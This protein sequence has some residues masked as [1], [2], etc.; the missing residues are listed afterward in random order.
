MIVEK[1][2]YM[3]NPILVLKRHP[4]DKYPFAFGLGKARMLV[5][6]YDDIAAFVRE[7]DARAVEKAVSVGKGDSPGR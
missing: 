4:N 2:E 5:E 7:G 1:S 3:G 6:A